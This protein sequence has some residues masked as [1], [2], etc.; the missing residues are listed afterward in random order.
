M[1][2]GERRAGALAEPHAE[3]EQGRLAHALERAAVGGLGRDMAEQAMVE[4]R[5]VHGEEHGGGGAGDI[6]VDDHRHAVEPRGEDGAGHGGDL[7]PAEAAQDLQR[8]VEMAGMAGD[9][10]GDGFALAL[11]PGVVD[12]GAGA[13]PVAGLAA[14]QA[15][16]DRR[17]NGRVADPHL[18][19]GEQIDPVGDRLH[20]VGHGPGAHLLVERRFHR[21]VAGRQV[22][23]EV[24]DLEAEIVGRGR[25]G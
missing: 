5:L 20:A 18:A 2:A 11:E 3:V 12:A 15:A 17:G 23:G 16:I 10:R 21:D 25:S 9:R 6:A 13:D 19:D 1:P 24:E 4:R 8:I 22:E 14:E 7:A